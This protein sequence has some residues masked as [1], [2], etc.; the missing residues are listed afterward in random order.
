MGAAG[1]PL[2]QQ[3]A[4]LVAYANDDVNGGVGGRVDWTSVV[5]TRSMFTSLLITCSPSTVSCTATE[6]ELDNPSPLNQTSLS[7]TFDCVRV[8][9]LSRRA[10]RLDSPP[11][12]SFCMTITA[13]A[14]WSAFCACSA[15]A[16]VALARASAS[17]RFL[18]LLHS[19]AFQAL[20][21]IK[22]AAARR[23]SLVTHRR[24]S[25]KAALA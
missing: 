13:R 16:T 7:P 24:L 22:Q 3:R 20:S 4:A 8:A 19:K 17:S 18:V 1:L 21:R 10:T 23:R 11:R 9:P 25:S 14:V 12:K 6:L 15:T 2:C 5:V